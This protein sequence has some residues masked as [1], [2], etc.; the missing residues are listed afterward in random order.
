MAVIRRKA[1]FRILSEAELQSWKG[2]ATAVVGDAQNRSQC[3]PPRHV[4]DS[5]RRKKAWRRACHAQ[6]ATLRAAVEPLVPA[7]NGQCQINGLQSHLAIKPALKEDDRV[8]ADIDDRRRPAP[9]VL[10]CAEVDGDDAECGSNALEG[11]PLEKPRLGQTHSAR[12]NPNDPI[13]C[14]HW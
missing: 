1:D 10:S 5:E 8:Q 12:A 7:V 11:T 2:V 4:K 3:N 14:V 9:D 6:L 13:V